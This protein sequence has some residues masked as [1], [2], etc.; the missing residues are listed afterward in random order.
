MNEP[1]GLDKSYWRHSL[2]GRVLLHSAIESA[3]DDAL[4]NR[5]LVE[6]GP[7]SALEGNLQQILKTYKSQNSYVP[8]LI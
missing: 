1:D 6:I 4:T 8:T 3:L 2:E 5:L 7:H